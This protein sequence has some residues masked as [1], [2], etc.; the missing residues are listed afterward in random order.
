MEKNF[1][2]GN[3]VKIE[4]KSGMY[5]GIILPRS[6]LSGEDHI[7]I[8]LNSGY[9][10]GI[11]KENIKILKKY[12]KR[13]LPQLLRIRDTGVI[14]G[15]G[16]LLLN[17][18]D[19]QMYGVVPVKTRVR[20]TG[21]D[22]SGVHCGGSG[23]I[24]MNQQVYEG[25]EDVEFPPDLLPDQKLLKLIIKNYIQLPFYHRFKEII[26]TPI[27]TILKKLLLKS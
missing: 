1:K 16:F 26:P 6:E 25:I 2:V 11:K 5:E 7:V 17:N 3:Y 14:T 24:Y 27:K 21:H 8:K 12:Y 9:N 4:A 20:N 23:D 15:D 13:Y 10:I 18:I 19:K 22:G